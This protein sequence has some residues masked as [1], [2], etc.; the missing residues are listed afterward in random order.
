MARRETGRTIR[1][2]PETYQR[3]RM[4]LERLEQA[5]HEGKCK[6]DWD[7]E[8]TADHFVNRLLDERESKLAR[9]IKHRQGRAA[10]RRAGRD[11]G[12]GAEG[13]ANG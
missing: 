6:A 3:F 13:N 8:L 9:S 12:P 2:R 4:L 1:V 10:K 5:S 7:G 11:A